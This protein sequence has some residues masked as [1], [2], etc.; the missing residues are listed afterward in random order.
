MIGSKPLIT[1]LLN[2][3]QRNLSKLVLAFSSV[4]CKRFLSDIPSV[5]KNEMEVKMKTS[6]L[7]YQTGKEI[8]NQNNFEKMERK[9]VARMPSTSHGSK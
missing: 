8:A 7:T 5:F 9:P 6:T 2:N 1:R 3:T 4:Q